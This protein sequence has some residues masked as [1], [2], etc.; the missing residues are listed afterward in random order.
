VEEGRHVIAVAPL[1][2]VPLW[3]RAGGALALT[4]P[5]PHTTSANWSQLTWHLH[6]AERVVGRLFED[7]G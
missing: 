4:E 6:A 7:V 1:D 3:L 5:A 2:T